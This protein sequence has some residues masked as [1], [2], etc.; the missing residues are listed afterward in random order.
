MQVVA[1][2]APPDPRWRWRIVDYEG[3]LVEESHETF[4]TIASAVE[5]G[6]KRLRSMEVADR[7]VPP[8]SYRSTYRRRIF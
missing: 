3:Q 5:Q 8:S 2:S 7:P 1:F 6:A 4:S